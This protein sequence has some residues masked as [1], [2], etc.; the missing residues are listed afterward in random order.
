MFTIATFSAIPYPAIVPSML[1]PLVPG[2]LPPGF[3]PTSEQQR[4][5][6][7]SAVTHAVLEAGMVFYNYGPDKPS[8]ANQAYPWF[9]TTDGR[10]YYFSGV[11]KS[12]VN[13]SLFERRIFTGS[14]TDLETYDGGDGGLASPTSGPMWEVDTVYNGRIL[15]GSGAIPTSSPAK[16]LAVGEDYGAGSQ[17]L[18]TAQLPAH[19][20]QVTTATNDSGSGYPYTG[21]GSTAGVAYATSQTGSGEA[22]SIIP[23][24]SGVLFIKWSGRLYYTV[25]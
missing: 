16:V 7:Y 10:W 24:V 9:R 5:N 8:V 3:C 11:W 12:P 2:T 22:V 25:T 14:T 13:Y 4:L 1:L 21:T 19:S 23:P 15:M 20:H 17:T 18:T 6:G